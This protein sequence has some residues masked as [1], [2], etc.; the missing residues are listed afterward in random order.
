MDANEILLLATGA[1]KSEAIGQSIEGPV[2]SMWPASILQMHERVTVLLDEPAA[3]ALERR[4]YYNWI[5]DQ[6]RLLLAQIEN[7]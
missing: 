7:S 1:E 4:D 2:S 6:K 5:Q 3:S